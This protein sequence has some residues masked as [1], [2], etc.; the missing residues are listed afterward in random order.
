MI[1]EHSWLPAANNEPQQR[2]VR[3]H[4]AII[5]DEENKLHTYRSILFYAEGLES[6]GSNN[7]S[8]SS[9]SL[10]FSIRPDRG[11]YRYVIPRAW[12]CYLVYPGR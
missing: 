10:A 11:E 2:T 3:I 5:A 12:Y 9:S 1:R 8:S 6:F 7:T 4:D